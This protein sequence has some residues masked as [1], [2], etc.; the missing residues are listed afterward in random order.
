MSILD[1]RCGHLSM[2]DPMACAR[3]SCCISQIS[4][5]YLQRPS[6]YMFVPF[7]ISESTLFQPPESSSPACFVCSWGFVLMICLCVGELFSAWPLPYGSFCSILYAWFVVDKTMRHSCS[8]VL[9]SCTTNF[10]A[11]AFGLELPFSFL[12]SLFILFLIIVVLDHMSIVSC[13]GR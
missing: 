1:W 10:Q 13:F 2:N 5:H 7:R 9:L 8:A 6:L 11:G 3:R 12:V 4:S